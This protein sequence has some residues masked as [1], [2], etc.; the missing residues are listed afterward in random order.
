VRAFFAIKQNST[1]EGWGLGAQFVF[2][3]GGRASSLSSLKKKSLH[4]GLKLKNP[5]VISCDTPDT[6]KARFFKKI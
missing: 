6:K 2:V 3:R 4:V 1:A 5:P